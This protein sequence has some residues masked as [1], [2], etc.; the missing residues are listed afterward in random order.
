MTFYVNAFHYLL[1]GDVIA[2]AGDAL[3]CT[4]T[5]DFEVNEVAVPHCIRALHCSQEL[6]FLS[7][8]SHLSDLPLNL[9]IAMSYG[10]LNF[11]IVGGYEH[12]WLYILNGA[13]VPELS[14]CIDEANISETVITKTLYDQMQAQAQGSPEALCTAEPTTTGNMKLMLPSSAESLESSPDRGMEEKTPPKLYPAR[15]TNRSSV[16]RPTRNHQSEG[17]RK[18]PSFEARKLERYIKASGRMSESPSL[19]ESRSRGVGRSLSREND[20]L[21]RYFAPPPVTSALCNGTVDMS[22][23]RHVTTMFLKLDSFRSTQHANPLSLQSF[24]LVVQ[25]ALHETGGFLRQFLVDDK[26][27]VVIGMWGVPTF[28]HINNALSA[29]ACSVLIRTRIRSLDHCCSIGIATGLV[30]CSSIGSS[31]RRDYVGIGDKVNLAA[32]LMGKA[33]GRVLLD[34]DSYS[35]CPEE[36]RGRLLPA[37]A[38][39]LKGIVQPYTPFAYESEEVPVLEEDISHVSY[40][41]VHS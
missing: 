28:S 29:L 36:V 18:S 25:M 33:K 41:I 15:P 6:I 11:A 9:H 40:A 20:D 19:A 13:C 5:D 24:V 35:L 8:G 34:I 1:G 14:S 26:G 27:C 3:L 30:Y 21:Q 37:E 38:M 22:E 32:R 10:E 39:R 7:S 2:F 23:L 16:S 12:Q 31:V 4:F 17:V